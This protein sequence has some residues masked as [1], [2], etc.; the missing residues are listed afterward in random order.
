MDPRDHIEI[1][2]LY[3]LYGHTMDAGDFE[4]WAGL[5]AP[6]GAWERVTEPG[7]EVVF[8]VKGREALVEFAREDYAGRGAGMGRHWM[9][10]IVLQ[11]EAPKATGRTYGFLIQSIDGEIKWIAHGNF[12]DDLVKLDE[13]WR[14]QRR[15]IFPLGDLTMPTDAK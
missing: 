13:G 4:G 8:S 5:F 3:A 2:E 14:F 11:G 6:D 7:G 9:G 12:Y 15:A 10:N 1:Q